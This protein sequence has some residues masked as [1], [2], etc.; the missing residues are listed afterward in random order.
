MEFLDGRKMPT[1]G[2]VLVENGSTMM[3]TPLTL[4]LFIFCTLQL[5]EV[6]VRNSSRV[7]F[8]ET[9]TSGSVHLLLFLGLSLMS[10]RQEPV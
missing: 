2:D 9:S 6:S 5:E 8:A 4:N 10:L 3:V 1:F 7:K